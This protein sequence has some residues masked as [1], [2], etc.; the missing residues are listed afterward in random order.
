MMA[1]IMAVQGLEETNGDASAA[2]LLDTYED[3]FRFD[4]PKGEVI[5]RPHDHVALQTLYFVEVTNVTDPQMEF[6]DLI[7]EFGPQDAAPPC[8]LPEDYADRCP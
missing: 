1:A 2:A 3:D 7:Q 8:N 4:G 6:V 5:I